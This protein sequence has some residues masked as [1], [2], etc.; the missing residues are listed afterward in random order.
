[1]GLSGTDLASGLAIGARAAQAKVNCDIVLHLP[2]RPDEGGAGSKQAD[3]ALIK[4]FG[5]R[6]HRPVTR[7]L[8][9]RVE[10]II[11]MLLAGKLNLRVEMDGPPVPALRDNAIRDC[12]GPMLIINPWQ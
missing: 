5:D 10:E 11:G 6:S 1:L 4:D 7:T 8:D 9:D 12:S 3:I 2:D